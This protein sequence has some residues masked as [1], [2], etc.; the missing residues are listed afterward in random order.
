VLNFAADVEHAVLLSIKGIVGQATVE[1][2]EVL[3]VTFGGKLDDSLFVYE[4]G[5]NERVQVATPVC[6][7]ITLEAAAVRAPFVVLQPG[8]IPNPEQTQFG[9][10]YHP[11][12]PAT[13]VESLTIHYRGGESYDRL[14][15][16][17]QCERD[18]NEQK[19][20]EWDEL[21]VEGQQM[22][23]SDPHPEEGL[24]VL[25]CR[26]ENTFVTIISD[27]PRDEMVKIA[28]SLTPVREQDD[29]V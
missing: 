14:W 12:R 6:E 13:K 7:D 3:D 23:I 27:L 20:F 2:H 21:L 29:E 25:S 24:R 26:R 17:Q 18:K 16:H 22:E 28:L 10:T 15:M 4:T 8:Y 1:A 5:V 11:A 19:E 9:V